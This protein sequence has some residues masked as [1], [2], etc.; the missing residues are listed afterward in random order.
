M[1][2]L[3]AT[4]R[5]VRRREWSASPEWRGGCRQLCALPRLRRSR[6]WLDSVAKQAEPFEAFTAVSWLESRSYLVNTLLRDTDSM[7]M[8]HSLEVRVPFLDHSLIEFMGGLPLAA[9]RGE[10][11]ALLIEALRDLLP[12]EVVNKPKQAF[13]LPWERWLRGALSGK[14]ES[15][16]AEMAPPLRGALEPA[17]VQKVWR[18]FQAGETSWSRPWSLY[19]L[20]EWAK[21]H[22]TRAN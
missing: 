12:T 3:A 1:K 17:E 4:A 19:V 16:L 13:T 6:A 18:Q 5:F 2:S 20:N 15:G 11:K 14:V 8:A 22:L 21:R 9:K 7:S 10:P